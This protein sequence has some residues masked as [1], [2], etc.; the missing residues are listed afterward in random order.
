M[1]NGKDLVPRKRGSG[2]TN[3]TGANRPAPPVM[4]AGPTPSAARPIRPGNGH[5]A[6][7]PDLTSTQPT[8]L[9]SALQQMRDGDF[10]VRLPGNWTGVGGKIADAFNEIAAANA[11]MAHE[12]SRVG[13][14]VGRRGQTR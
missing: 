2:L 7:V 1:A 5:A 14:V 13:D 11:R 9:L 12:L 8:V 3:P 10:S 6:A 4:T